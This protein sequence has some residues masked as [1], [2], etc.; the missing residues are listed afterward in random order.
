MSDADLVD[1]WSLQN[2]GVYQA[3]GRTAFTCEPAAHSPDGG[4]TGLEDLKISVY[5]FMNLCSRSS[6]LRGGGGGGRVVS[7]AGSSRRRGRKDSIR[8]LE[9]SFRR[10]N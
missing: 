4:S 5:F 1:E 3:Q 2:K 9:I 8:A 6:A 10:S 7:G